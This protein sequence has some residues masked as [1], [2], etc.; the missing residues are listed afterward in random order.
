MTEHAGLITP[1]SPMLHACSEEGCSTIVLGSGTCVEHDQPPSKSMTS[2]LLN[3]AIT[4]N[5]P[6]RQE[7]S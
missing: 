4:A 1:L 6:K 2:T 5:S 3:Q 7:A